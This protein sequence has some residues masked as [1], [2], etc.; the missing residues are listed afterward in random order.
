[1]REDAMRRVALVAVMMAALCLLAS[2]ARADGSVAN[3]GGDQPLGVLT[4]TVAGPAMIDGTSFNGDGGS[5][6][7]YQWV[8]SITA[9]A[10]STLT[11]NYTFANIYNT[12]FAKIGMRLTYDQPTCE[13]ISHQSSRDWVDPST[14]DGVPG[15][16]N[17]RVYCAGPLTYTITSR[18]ASYSLG[19]S[20]TGVLT[21]PSVTYAWGGANA[22]TCG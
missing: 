20:Y 8:G 5:S 6:A 17:L 7:Q 4:C 18:A 16:I 21:A 2:P 11:L 12:L 10:G 3:C 15:Q 9:P 22:T 19:G 13:S 14:A 1:M